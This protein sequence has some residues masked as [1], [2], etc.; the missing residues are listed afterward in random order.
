MLSTAWEVEE[1]LRMAVVAAEDESRFFRPEKGLSGSPR[2]EA[3]RMSLS[4][5][6]DATMVPGDLSPGQVMDIPRSGQIWNLERKPVH[7]PGKPSR[8]AGSPY[9]GICKLCLEI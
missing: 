6:L 1:R 4:F 7:T 3:A 8:G 5:R 9:R 2:G